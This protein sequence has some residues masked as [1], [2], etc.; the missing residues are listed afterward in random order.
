MWYWLFL[1]NKSEL[2]LYEN[3]CY[4]IYGLPFYNK[5]LDSEFKGEFEALVF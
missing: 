5:A 3:Q 4:K 2:E 1:I